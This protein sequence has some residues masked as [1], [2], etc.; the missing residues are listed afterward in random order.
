MIG[1]GRYWSPRY[2][3]A[4]FWAKVGSSVAYPIN[5]CDTFSAGLTGPRITGRVSP[6]RTTAMLNARRSSG[7]YCENA[8]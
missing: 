6:I 2:W 7:S 3:A 4:R 1:S 8:P 5:I